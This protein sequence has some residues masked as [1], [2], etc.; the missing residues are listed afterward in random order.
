M[1]LRGRKI[2][3]AASDSESNEFLRS[4]WRQMLLATLPTRFANQIDRKWS[5]KNEVAA[6][7]QAKYVPNGLRVVE[8]LL[9][10]EFSAEDVAVCYTDQMGTF[11]G[12]ETRVVGV[13]AHNPLGITFATDVYA[14]LYGRELEPINAAEFRRLIQHPALRE[15]KHHL[16]LIVGGPGAWQ[17][18]HKKMQDEWQIDC[19][20]HGEAED[21]VLGLFQS[22]LRGESLPR[23]VEGRSPELSSI[24][25]IRH[26]A[27]FGAVEITRGCGRGCQFCSVAL[28]AGK[29][30]PLEQVLH[31][32]RTQVAEGADTVLLTTE[33]IFLYEQGPKF[34]TNVPALKR[35]FESVAAVAGVNYIMLTHGTMAPAVRQPELIAELSEI[36]VGRSVNQHWASTHPEHRYANLFVGLE[37]GSTRIF[38]EQMKG[39]AYPYRPEQWPDVVLRGMEILNKH[40]WF[41]FCTFILGL[42]G[43]TREDTKQSLDLLFALKDAKWCVIPTLFVPLEDTRLGKKAGAK[44]VEMSDLQWEFFFT[45][46]RYN[47]DFFRKSSQ[48]RFSLAIPLYYYLIGRKN[49]GTEMK[50]PLYRLAHFPERMLSRKLYLDL[51]GRQTPKYRVPEHVPI[52]EER[53][54]PPIPELAQIAPMRGRAAEAD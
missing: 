12:E 40:N 18:E 35:L 25:P 50:Y 30:I 51:S 47:L 41:P 6:D 53:M 29:S 24:P 27:T 49:F 15:H 39:K 43:E 38:K 9:L 8:A 42:P 1:T 23:S 26:R 14:K 52:P 44:L 37:T 54:R 31:N 13:H 4:T 28:R 17:I 19:L 34:E 2:V 7:G 46:W 5:L 10:R 21:I 48:W 20:V 33:D 36:A 3:L 45:C 32:V 11:I 22:A 16:N